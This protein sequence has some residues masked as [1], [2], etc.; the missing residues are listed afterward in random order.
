MTE[1]P[2]MFGAGVH[3]SC[4]REL[5]SPGGAILVDISRYLLAQRLQLALNLLLRPDGFLSR[6]IESAQLPVHLAE[7]RVELV[8]LSA[9]VSWQHLERTLQA[10][11]LAPEIVRHGRSFAQDGSAASGGAILSVRLRISPMASSTAAMP[12]PRSS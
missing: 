4:Q 6:F 3:E 10:F 11:E 7:L 8:E 9:Q 1:L 5:R 2:I 12:A